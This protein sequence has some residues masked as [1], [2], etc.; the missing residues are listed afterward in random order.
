MPLFFAKSYLNEN[1]ISLRILS[2][3][4]LVSLGDSGLEA[5]N[6]LDLDADDLLKK[7]IIHAKDSRI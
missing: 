1:D 6:K 3:K 4:G 7:I 5:I 2:A